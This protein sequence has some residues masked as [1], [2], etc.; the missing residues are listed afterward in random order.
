MFLSQISLAIHGV[1]D[2]VHWQKL[3]RRTVL[4]LLGMPRACVTWSRRYCSLNVWPRLGLL[5]F[6]EP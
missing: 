3:S 2:C 5:F 1:Y 4:S 6:H